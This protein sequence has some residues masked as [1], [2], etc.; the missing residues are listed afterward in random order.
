MLFLLCSDQGAGDIMKVKSVHIHNF[1]SIY[2]AKIS[3]TD[4]SILVGENNVGKSNVIDAIR[5]FYGDVKFQEQDWHRFRPK[6]DKE[7]WIE[8]EYSLED[9][10]YNR[11]GKQYRVAP[12]TLTVRKDLV[13]G[14][15]HGITTNG[16]AK[17]SFYNSSPDNPRALGNIIYVPAVVDVKENVNMSGTSALS[18]LV[19]T[20]CQKP[21]F[22]TQYETQIRTFLKGLNAVFAPCFRKV[23]NDIN[24]EIGSTGVRVN[25]GPRNNI[26]TADMSKFILNV[27]VQEVGADMDLN[28]LGTGVQRR[29]ISSLIKTSVQYSEQYNKK[30]ANKAP[31]MPQNHNNNG[32]SP[33]MD[34]LLFEE[35]EVSLHPEAI[36]DLAYDL[37]KF[38]TDKYQQVLATTHSSLLLSEDVADINSVIRVEKSGKKTVIHQSGLPETDLN[39]IRNLVYFDRPR[40]DM[41]FSKKVVLVEGPTEYKLYDYLRRRGD[42]PRNLAQQATVIE[43]VGKWSMPYFIKVLNGLNIR[44]SLLYDLDGNPNRQ[45]NLDVQN[46]CTDLL[47]YSYGF[48]KDIETFCGTRKQGNHVINLIKEF[49]DGTIPAQTQNQVVDIFKKLLTHTK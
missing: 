11:L 20:I 8:I 2:D 39:A 46:A 31:N 35:P 48:P 25:I 10:E 23:N 7:A 45:D 16:L 22:V 21:S 3:L 38:A 30:T 6:S 13:S 1:R 14:N 24:R 27:A 29:I 49:D 33:R 26:S 36:K 12:N 32:F 40:S 44:Y 41:F 4:Y 28:Q 5:C 42:I 19:N 17:T 9:A 47:D 43:T 18:G 15:Y 34:L 37:R